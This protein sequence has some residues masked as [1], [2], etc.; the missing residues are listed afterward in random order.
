MRRTYFLTELTELRKADGING[1][2]MRKAAMELCG[3]WHSQTPAEG[4][5]FGERVGG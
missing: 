5:R 3:Q 4:S 1:I 2:F